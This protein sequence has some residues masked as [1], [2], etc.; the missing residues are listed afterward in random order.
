VHRPS[1]RLKSWLAGL[2]VSLPW[3]SGVSCLPKDA[4]D[5]GSAEQYLDLR[6]STLCSMSFKCCSAELLQKPNQAECEKR[7]L[8][9]GSF[10]QLADAVANGTTKIDMNRA[11]SCFA[12]VRAM[13]CSAWAAALAGAVPASCIGIFS[14]KANG[15]SCKI[16]AEC[17]SQF[18]DL[19]SGD[20][21]LQ[22]PQSSGLCAAPAAA[23]GTCPA[24]QNGC[25]PGA[26]CRGTG[27]TPICT[28]FPATG[29]ACTDD[30]DCV[31]EK[32]VAGACAAA[33]WAAPN[34]DHLLGT[35]KG[36]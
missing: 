11:Q 12:E 7:G 15:Q 3:L 27:G 36:F 9:D 18:C 28:A 22:G 26:Q 21:T 24:S 13:S 23:G 25:V 6:G 20:H 31:S 29:G 16:D 10:A 35:T 5:G 19:T 17:T 14:G 2:L 33:C 32:C 8:L 34:S 4:D 30:L 1:F